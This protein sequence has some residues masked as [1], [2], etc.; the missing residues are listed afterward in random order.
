MAMICDLLSVKG[1]HVYSIGLSASVRDAAVIMND[2][3][4]GAL[5]VIDQG[6][7]VGIFTERDVLRRVVAERR[8][9]STATVED[10]MT[11]DIVTCRPD[12]EVDQASQLMTDR[13]VRHLPVIDEE[14]GM[15]GLISIGDLNAFHSRSQEKTIYH[16][17]EYIYG[18]S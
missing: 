8:D 18:R 9:P 14:G 15:V 13:R 2:Y 16:L 1:S 5:V 3:K 17:H 11:R 4:I 10:V 6:K 7:V 12:T